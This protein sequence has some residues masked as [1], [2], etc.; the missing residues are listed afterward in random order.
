MVP[1]TH[2]INPGASVTL[3]LSGLFSPAL[4]PHVGI[5][6]PQRP[7]VHALSR[8]D[9]HRN[10]Q[11]RWVLGSSETPG[12]RRTPEGSTLF[13]WTVASAGAKQ[14]NPFSCQPVLSEFPDIGPHCSTLIQF[15]LSSPRNDPARLTSSKGLPLTVSSR[16][17]IIVDK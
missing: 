5:G 12:T 7:A 11:A 2:G 6:T 4:T 8:G 10:G 16:R 9:Q 3:L 1:R 17:A 14:K 13:S 15:P